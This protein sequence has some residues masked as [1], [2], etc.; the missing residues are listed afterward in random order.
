MTKRNPLFSFSSLAFLLLNNFSYAQAKEGEFDIATVPMRTY[1]Q[2]PYQS[3]SLT[4]QLRSAHTPDYNEAFVTGSMASVWAKGDPFFLDYYQNQVMSGVNFRIN[5]KWSAEV[6]LQ[7]TWAADNQL[8][9][10]T[11]EFH[12]FF[13][14]G[15]NGREEVDKHSFTIESEEDGIYVNDF[16]GEEM[17]RAI[18]GYLQYQVWEQDTHAVAVGGTLY[19]QQLDSGIFEQT[20][21]EQGLQVNYSYLNHDHS[22]FATLGVNRFDD[23]NKVLNTF[24]AR[25][26]SFALAL[27]YGYRIQKNHEILLQYH[28]FQGILEDDEGDFSEASNEVVIGYRYYMERSLFE[29]S[30]TENIQNMDNSTDIAFT[31]G[32]RHFFE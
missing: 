20:S 28:G 32:Y 25:E 13:G 1:A 23:S 10:L 6:Q 18:H 8:D 30:S 21:F 27:G 31:F 5:D 22:A 7:Y 4:T 12:D 29:F 9:T 3:T 11:M 26:Y 19:Y 2:S 16:E 15:Q 24:D 17:G 14:L